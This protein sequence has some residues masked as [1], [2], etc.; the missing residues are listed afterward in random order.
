[1]VC[2]GE[3]VVPFPCPVC[4][5]AP[6]KVFSLLAPCSSCRRVLLFCISH[7]HWQVWQS[8]AASEMGPKENLELT[9]VF[10]MADRGMDLYEAWVQFMRLG[11]RSNLHLLGCAT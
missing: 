5:V 7:V 4:R 8:L 1:M 3:I 6:V 9:K 10:T 2:S 11:R